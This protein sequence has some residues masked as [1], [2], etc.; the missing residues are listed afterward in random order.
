MQLSRPPCTITH[1]YKSNIMCINLLL[2]KIACLVLRKCLLL[3]SGYC[4]KLRQKGS[5]LAR[6]NMDK[7]ES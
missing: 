4:L 6:Q 5:F 3:S 1:N 2:W 7:S